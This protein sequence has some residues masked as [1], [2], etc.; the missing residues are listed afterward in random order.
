MK[1]EALLFWEHGTLL[2][3][4]HFQLLEAAH[5]RDLALAASLTGPWPWG[6][7]SLTVDEEALATGVVSLVAL[8]IVFPDGCHA[9]PGE[10]ALLS[11]CSV[12]SAWHNLEEPL[13]V[14]LGLPA[15]RHDRPNVT[16]LPSLTA[17]E[18]AKAGTR[19]VAGEEPDERADMLAGGVAADVR[20]MYLNLKLVAAQDSDTASLPEDLI[21]V[22]LLRLVHRGDAI[23]ADKDFLPPC[24]TIAAFPRLLSLVAGVRNA[25]AGRV[26]QL[27]DFKLTAREAAGRSGRMPL[28]AQT[29]ALHAML[30]VL[31][32]H[33]PL[34]E[35]VCES[36]CGHPWQIYGMLRQL[37]GEL[38]I[39]SQE[40]SILGQRRD[41]SQALPPY[42]HCD[43]CGCLGAAAALVSELVSLLATGPAHI[44]PLQRKGHLW[45]IFLPEHARSDYDFW[46]QIRTED[47]DFL[48]HL[49]TS[50]LRF[51]SEEAMPV[52]LSRSLP[53]VPLSR[54]DIPQGLPRREDTVCLLLGSA[55][56]LWS[57][58]QQTGKAALFLPSA[59][60][61]TQVHLVLMTPSASLTR[62]AR[63]EA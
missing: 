14:W 42:S 48:D 34:F 37:A 24:T 20:F 16:V 53:G 43:P 3:P 31:A 47:T 2:Q 35:H 21:R 6:V 57:Q 33:L 12:L 36:G 32:R 28:T 39:F 29:M 8:D 4:Q 15:L 54:E 45:T 44:L 46:L 19:F 22:P 59:P 63:R 51:A 60:E 7:R 11:P 55:S 56:S 25:L 1:T 10:N 23:V 26:Q 50:G 40:V 17:G 52:L 30:Q 41:K 58:I 49:A 61:D 38:S 27:E 9:V 13:M 18:I 62:M 5:A